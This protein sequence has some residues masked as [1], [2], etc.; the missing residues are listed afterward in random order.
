MENTG[1]TSVG[2]T[3]DFFSNVFGCA[4]VFEGGGYRGAYTAGIANVLLENEVWFD[5]VCGLSAGASHTVDYVS[6]DQLRVKEAFMARTSAEP[7]G[8]LGTFL[9]GKG[10]F[11][12]DYLYEGCIADGTGPFAWDDFVANPAR[13]RIQAFERDT[14]RTVTF[15]KDDMPDVWEAIKRVRAS[16]TIP[17]MMNPEPVD[18]RVLLDGGLGEG[19]GIPVPMAEHDGFERMVF[20]ATREAGYRKAPLSTGALRLMRRLFGK[21]PYLLDAVITRPAR[22]NEALDHVAEL[23]RE[24]RALVIRP[25]TMPVKNS[26]LDIAALEHAYELGHEQGLRELD[27]ILKFVGLA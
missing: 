1:N 2:S 3:T 8:G 12:A 25:D 7:A 11:N 22:Y 23:E 19:A 4:L 21:Y 14:G 16:S 17:V 5:Y 18:G 20:V 27:R 15:T 9:R 6:R 26:T 10:Y 13:I 24:G